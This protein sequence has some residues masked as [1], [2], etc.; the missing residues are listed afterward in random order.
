MMSG[1]SKPRVLIYRDCLLPRSE[2]F[3]LAQGE[4][5]SR[6]VPWYF[7]SRLDAGIATPPERTLV[8]NRGSFFGRIEE[9]GHKQFCWSTPTIRRAKRIQPQ[10]IHAHFGPD[11][12][13]AVS[14]SRKLG[15]PMIASFHGYD[16][17]TRDEIFRTS[18]VGRRYLRRRS[19]IASEAAQII[20]V[21]EYVKSRLVKQS[22]PETKITV[23]YTGVDTHTFIPDQSV[24]REPVVLFVGR[25]VEVKGCEHLIRA[26]A[27]IQAEIPEAE[28][29][30]AGDGPLRVS[31]ELQAKN[32]LHRYRFIGPQDQ[33][34]VRDWMNRAQVFCV[35]SITTRSG[36]AE[37]FGM[38]FVEAQAMG[39]PV[40]SFSSGGIPEAV[41]HGETG[42]LVPE[43][44]W[45]QLSEYILS[46]LRN[47]ALWCRFSAASLRRV[48][49]MFNLNRQSVGL[50]HIYDQVIKRNLTLSNRSES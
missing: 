20:A 50:E 2:T 17:T 16:A 46:L 43:G 26:M 34:V 15:I 4:S 23:H 27:P 8:I 37:G 18:R 24:V 38:V 28:L 41:A 47:R 36:A 39:L 33:A 13:H 22:Y 30:V 7:G 45:R 5:L 19:T 42:W 10:L 35:P 3:I 25:L 44:N 11:S 9:I 48:S 29:V 31:L 12:G 32:T 21:S 6:Y 40:V 1:I 49:E 14:L